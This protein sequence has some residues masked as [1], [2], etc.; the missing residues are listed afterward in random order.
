M[1]WHSQIAETDSEAKQERKDDTCFDMRVPS[2]SCQGGTCD[3]LTRWTD[4]LCCWGC[5][6]SCLCR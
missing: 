6:C 3:W 2:C 1:A 4:F 5:L